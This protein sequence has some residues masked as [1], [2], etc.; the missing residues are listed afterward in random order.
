MKTVL[1]M[2]LLFILSAIAI[3]AQNGVIKGKIINA[4]LQTGMANVNISVSVNK[5]STVSN[6]KGDFTI[7]SVEPG[8]YILTFTSVGF[9]SV[10]KE[11]TVSGN[12]IDLGKIELSSIPVNLGE[13][14]VSSTKFDKQLKDVSIPMVVLSN[15]D[16]KTKNATT[17]VELLKN[18]P[19]LNLGRDGIWGTRLNIRGFSKEAVVTLID[20]N[21]VETA[22]NIAASLSLI[23]PSAI[24]R[25]EVIKGSASSLYGTGAVGGVIN[26]ITNK[27]LFGGNFNYGGS[28]SSGYNSVNKSISNSLSLNVGDNNWFAK[29]SGSYRNAKDTKTPLGILKDSRFKDNSVFA[30]IG[31]KPFENHEFIF[32]YQL[33][34]AK[35]VGIPGGAS[36]PLTASARYPD[37]KRELYSFD[38]K[39]YNL[40]SNLATLEFKTFYQFIAR[41]VEVIPNATTIMNP[42]ADHYTTGALLQTNWIFGTNR[43]VVGIDAWQRRYQ[44]S[45]ERYLSN[46]KRTIYDKP[47]PDAKYRSIGL[48]AQDE[49]NALSDN[50]TLTLGGRIDQ[51][52][53]KND[54]V[55]NPIYMINNGVINYNPPKTPGASFL[56][57]DKSDISWSANFAAIYKL[58]NNTDFT[59]NLARSFRSPA[60]EERFQYIDLGGIIYLGN[61]DLEPE[62]GYY[63]D[64]GTRFWF[65]NFTFKVNLFAN[66]INNYIVD[67]PVV[68]DSLYVKN[69]VSK[70]RIYG[71]DLSFEYELI[72][73]FVLYGNASY[74]RGK[75]T[76]LDLDLPEIP[77][78]NGKLGLRTTYFNY[79]TTDLTVNIF[80]DQTDGKINQD[81]TKWQ[82]HTPGYVTYDLYLNSMPINL[83]STNIT[84][85]AGIEN[86]TDRAYRNSLSTNRGIIKLEP[87]RNY[88]AKI[89][90]NW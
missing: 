43:L 39:A 71:F 53:V 62:N 79:F 36:L 72:K 90:L 26:I 21:R 56:A 37:E 41:D 42:R 57:G 58:T 22:N 46:V 50:L 60:L 8:T 18:E 44:G 9:K 55:S 23:D 29:V 40:F 10:T 86:I 16:F 51:I 35:D 66:F 52:N 24:E 70:A 73:S 76:E 1:K 30:T 89:S 85:S 3:N 82:V 49:F 4:E 61:P 28:Y 13:I 31:Y 7:N 32:D 14:T 65:T 75:D 84:I 67:N 63:I 33:F 77:P 48:F 27:D 17:L 5:L 20:G 2:F 12:I 47:I 69:N 34:N 78:L 6:S 74:S 83:V 80:D 25:V 59:L 11:V 81:P 54:A 64:F 88:F 15:E 45:R 68:T 87:G 19:G 38:Y